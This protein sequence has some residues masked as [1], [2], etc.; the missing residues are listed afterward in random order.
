MK[1]VDAVINKKNVPACINLYYC[2]LQLRRYVLL[3]NTKQGHI[4]PNN[5]AL[6]QPHIDFIY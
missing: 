2:V 6:Y 3:Y 4:R 5:L 1:E